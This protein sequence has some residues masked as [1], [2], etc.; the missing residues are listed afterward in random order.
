MLTKEI[1][2]DGKVF[3][4]L[5]FL[6]VFEDFVSGTEEVL[7]SDFSLE[8]EVAKVAGEYSARR[9]KDHAEEE[10]DGSGDDDDGAG[11]KV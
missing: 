5:F 7:A 6:G 1:H 9:A 4:R 11:G 8:L 2:G 10:D 3:E